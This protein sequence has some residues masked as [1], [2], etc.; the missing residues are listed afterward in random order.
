MSCFSCCFAFALSSSTHAGAPAGLAVTFISYA[1]LDAL[2]P[3]VLPLSSHSCF[4]TPFLTRRAL[5]CVVTLSP[6]R[7]FLSDV[8]LLDSSVFSATYEP[9][10]F[11]YP[12]C[13]LCCLHAVEL[14]SPRSGLR[15]RFCVFALFF[16]FFGSALTWPAACTSTL[17]RCCSPYLSLLL[18]LFPALFHF[19]RVFGFRYC[20]LRPSYLALG[21]FEREGSYFRPNCC[22]FASDIS[23]L[24]QLPRTVLVTFRL[25]LCFVPF[26][27]SVRAPC[28]CSATLCS[29][30]LDQSLTYWRCLFMVLASVC[31]FTLAS[32]WDTTGDLPEPGVAVSAAG[33]IADL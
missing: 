15:L 26:H 17:S 20:S 7:V 21:V 8:H 9:F 16:R 27:C 13:V 3:S 31:L 1:F 2:L 33:S 28:S 22:D 4:E 12:T 23:V 18:P 32:L 10:T 24:P 14:V 6:F 25:V 19:Y 29:L 30:S 11:R 5:S